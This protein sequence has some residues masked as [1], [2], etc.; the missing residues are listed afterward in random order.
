MAGIFIYKNGL[1]YDS[2]AAPDD[3]VYQFIKRNLAEH[4]VQI[5]WEKEK[6]SLEKIEKAKKIK[7]N[8]IDRLNKNSIVNLEELDYFFK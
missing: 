7:D 2:F 1:H 3:R 6:T 4:G 5:I 8:L